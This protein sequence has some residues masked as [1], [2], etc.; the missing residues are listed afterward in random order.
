MKDTNLKAGRESAEHTEHLATVGQV[1]KALTKLVNGRK[2][3]A[4]NN[5]RLEQFRG[6]FDASLRMLFDVQD[7]LVLAIEQYAMRWNDEVVYENAAREE[8]LAYILFRDGIGE[9]TIGPGAIG[10]EIGRLIDILASE[11]HSRDADEDVVTRLWT[12]DFQ[13][14]SYRVVDDYLANE[15][16]AGAAEGADDP[17]QDETSDHPELLPSLA[18]SGRI[19]VPAPEPLQS[20]DSFLRRTLAS[21]HPE[22][23]DSQRE[24]LYQRLL[25]TSFAVAGEEVAIYTRE[26]EAEKADDGVASFVDAILV[27]VLLGDNPSAVRDVMAIVDRIVDYAV[28][29]KQPVTLARLAQL[30]REFSARTDL[31]DPVRV[32]CKKQFARV[33]NPAVLAALFERI[34]RPGP[35]MDATLRYAT[36]MGRD[37]VEPLTRV[38]HRIEG[39]TA[40]RMICD[41]LIAIAGDSN[42]DV[43]MA[44]LERFDIDH[45][46]VALDAVHIARSLQLPLSPRLR[47]LM[48]YPEPRV[49]LEMIEWLAK[50]QDDES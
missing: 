33:A 49:K 8:S 2:I 10:D 34:D 35:Y 46:A 7:E 40:H 29:E 15:Y 43:V 26:L 16:G 25:R 27:F 11:L 21:H 32:F 4:E 23:D 30:V 22:G 9:L 47:E 50:R 38:L 20:I 19:I 13:H 5:P 24:A 14:I 42:G 28:E 17:R 41:T 12:A 3:Y 1:L 48:F 6:E 36:A 31:P 37:A 45:P 39:S 18:D 44:A